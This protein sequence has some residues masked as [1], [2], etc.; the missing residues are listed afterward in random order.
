MT[1]HAT[2]NSAA[3]TVAALRNLVRA[4]PTVEPDK[5]GP[6]YVRQTTVLELLDRIGS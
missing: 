4:L 5:G 2:P 3:V 1:E 6:L